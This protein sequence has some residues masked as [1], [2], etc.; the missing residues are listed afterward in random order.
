M[1]IL[2]FLRTRRRKRSSRTFA[3]TTLYTDEYNQTDT[4]VRVSPLNLWRGILYKAAGVLL[5]RKKMHREKEERFGRVGLAPKNGL[6]R[7]RGRSRRTIR[8][9]EIDESSFREKKRMEHKRHRVRYTCKRR[10]W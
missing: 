9:R 4:K 7:P 6:R 8:N 2:L 5:K 1:A 3:S 10:A